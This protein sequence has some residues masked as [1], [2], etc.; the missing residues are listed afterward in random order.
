M[1]GGIGGSN[2]TKA[3]PS[4]AATPMDA[5]AKKQSLQNLRMKGSPTQLDA[6]LRML[7]DLDRFGRSDL[8]LTGVDFAEQ[9][10]ATDVFRGQALDLLTRDGSFDLL[11]TD[12]G[13]PGM[14]GE[15][16]AAEVQAGRYWLTWPR[17]K[18][19]S[20]GMRMFRDWLHAEGG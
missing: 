10:Q 6:R 2:G 15:E 1:L 16:L 3:T 19:P 5:A 4:A 20:V 11:L 18:P 14:S 9:M 7:Q 13:L 17:A 8:G 12:L